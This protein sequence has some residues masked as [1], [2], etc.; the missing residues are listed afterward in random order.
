MLND[1]K[2]ITS[3]FLENE[4]DRNLICS[5]ANERAYELQLLF[6]FFSRKNNEGLPYSKFPSYLNN[7]ILEILIL[8]SN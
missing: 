3:F 1:K 6:F 5:Y 2:D 4:Y 8:N 7:P